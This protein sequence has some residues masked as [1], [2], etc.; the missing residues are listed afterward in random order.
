M[1]LKL[2]GSGLLVLGGFIAASFAAPQ[3]EKDAEKM[4]KMMEMMATYKKAAVPTEIHKNLAAMAGTWEQ[5][6][7]FG[8]TA[9]PG[10]VEYRSILGGRF[11][12]G[13]STMKMMGPNGGPGEEMQGFHVLGYD[14]V[15]KQFQSVWT[16]S[17]STGIMFSTGTP[18]ASGK[19]VTFESVAK[20]AVTPEGRPFKMVMTLESPDK[21]LLEIWDSA[22]DGKTLQK[23]GTITATRK[24]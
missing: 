13:E 1:I 24:K 20:D 16:D 6:C 2:L 3:D 10:T 17:M 18:D 14:N 8:G 23:V 11:V 12:V 22:E 19:V 4:K 5:K 15:L 21:H 7:D 9:T